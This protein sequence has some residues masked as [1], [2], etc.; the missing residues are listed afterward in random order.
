MALGAV[1]DGDRV[2]ATATPRAGAEPPSP[3]PLTAVEAAT[4]ADA[5]SA[6]IRVLAAEDNATNQLVLTTIMQIFGFELTIAGDGREAV[7]LWRAGG[8]DVVLMDIQMPVMD[9]VAATRAIRSLEAAEGRTRTPILAL[10]ANALP[11]Q[12]ETYHAAGMD[13][14][15][16]KPIELARLQAA[17]EA[18]LLG[19]AEQPESIAA[20][21]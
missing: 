20:S 13:G 3:A 7:E 17:L 18:V 21:A 4:E 15:V 11:Q 19:D 9:G 1:P 10:S 5:G 16:P 8:F 6:P 12:V 2:P 14:H